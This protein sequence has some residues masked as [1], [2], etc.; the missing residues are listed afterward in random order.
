MKEFSGILR[1]IGG[2]STSDRVGKSFVRYSSL[3]VGEKIL[4]KI[5][6][7]RSVGDYLER[8]LGKQVTV[9]MNGPMIVGVKMADGKLYYWKRS[10]T[11]VIFCLVFVPF[12]G[13]GLL[14]ALFLYS[15]LYHILVAQRL[16]A[17]QGG[18]GMGS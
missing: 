15:D 7:A 1:A 12:Y 17:S 6:T 16:L 18:I 9:Y 14:F 3:E 4:R 5:R 11:V 10:L 2:S 8:G 13:M